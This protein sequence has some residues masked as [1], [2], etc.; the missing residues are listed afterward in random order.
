MKLP[1]FILVFVLLST[2]ILAQEKTT[3]TV[4]IRKV[5]VVNGVEKIIDTTYTSDQVDAVPD[6]AIKTEVLEGLSGDKLPNQIKVIELGNP[7]HPGAINTMSI[8]V[9]G[10][11]SE[12]EAKA[13][14]ELRARKIELTNDSK[15]ATS[16]IGLTKSVHITD[17]GDT[18]VMLKDDVDL[19]I[20]VKDGQ[21]LVIK[22]APC[23]SSQEVIMNA[24]VEA[25]VTITKKIV[26]KDLDATDQQKLKASTNHLSGNEL[27]I[28]DLKFS[29]N[30]NNGKFNLSFS[31]KSH[32][33]V[34]VSI[35]NLEGKSVY[36]ESLKNFTGKYSRDMDLSAQPKGG[37]YVKIAQKGKASMK[38]MVID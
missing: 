19:N 11:M 27:S 2:S 25:I 10:N 13:F 31:L 7:A 17:S 35:F 23:G 4:H 37:Y 28:D 38:K 14:H 22:K 9:L 3:A 34:Q 12:E 21:M 36:E 26:I 8:S 6:I 32:E 20:D 29:P 5:E 24:P 33:D 18:I 16:F 1:I 15:N 30:P